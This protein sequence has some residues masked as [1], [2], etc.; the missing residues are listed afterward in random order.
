MGSHPPNVSG[1]CS[2]TPAYPLKLLL[3]TTV[4]P[5]RPANIGEYVTGIR[6]VR[7]VEN[8]GFLKN[9]NLAAEHASGKY[10]L[11]LNNDTAVT[12]NWLEPL[13]ELFDRASVGVVGPKLLFPNGKLQEA[14]GIVWQD[15]SGWNFGRADDPRAPQYN[16][17]RETDYVSGAAL[18][19]RQ[20]LWSD[21]G[22]FDEVFVPAYYEDTDL[23]FQ[24]RQAGL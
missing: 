4:R 24:A 10:L 13:V 17:V 15:A 7:Q 11:F 14:G 5:T 18:M 3:P 9:C 22:G 1:L 12:S 2:S 8:Q 21:L 23:C 19:I 16:Y 6:V 20:S